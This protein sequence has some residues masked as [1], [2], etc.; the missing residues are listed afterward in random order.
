MKTLNE[1]IAG[2]TIYTLAQKRTNYIFSMNERPPTILFGKG[3]DL[4]DEQVM[5]NRAK[6]K[7]ITQ[8]LILALIDVAI[9]NGDFEFA[10]TYWNTYHC[11]NKVHKSNGRLFGKYCKNRFCTIC[12]GIRKADI[13]N[14]YLPTMKRWKKPYIV[15]LTT[16]AIF[17]EELKERID[18][19]MIWFAQILDCCRKRH[20]RGIGMKPAIKLVGIRA[21]ECNFNPQEQ[22][23]NPHIHLIVETREMAETIKDEWLKR[24][25]PECALHYGQYR[26]TIS[27]LEKELVEVVKYCT[28]IFTDPTTEKEKKKVKYKKIKDPKIYVRAYHNIIMAML[29][30]RIFDR[31]GFNLPKNPKTTSRKETKEYE[32]WGYSTLM[33]D[34]INKETQD[35]LT[36]YQPSNELVS[37]LDND[38]DKELQ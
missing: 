2:G 29:G 33:N 11:L 19:M 22:T 4:C 23:Y 27:N 18:Q 30:H 36:G 35:F 16:R 20:N 10:Q 28:K 12:T 25:T 32:D 14:R 26:A 15:V 9:A 6:K 38:I 8:K 37:I 24:C 13:I 17:A 31:F 7:F 21:I 3:I 1:K 5:Q 34:W